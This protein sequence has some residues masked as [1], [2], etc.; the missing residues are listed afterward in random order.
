MGI[1]VRLPRLVML[2]TEQVA[3]TPGGCMA[4]YLIRCAKAV[5]RERW[6][7]DDEL[8]PL[9]AIGRAQAAALAN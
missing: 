1:G 5:R 2:D 6:D 4:M 7:E 3:T 8:R 9:T